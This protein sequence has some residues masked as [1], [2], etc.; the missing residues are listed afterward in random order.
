MALPVIAGVLGGI[1]A[2]AISVAALGPG[3]GD[4]ITKVMNRIF[5]ARVVPETTLTRLFWKGIITEDEFYEL[6]KFV[7]YGES[8][9]Y[10]IQASY[11]DSIS[12]G[13][14]VRLYFRYISKVDNPYG[15]NE[16]WVSKR[17]KQA[18]V[19]PSAHKEILEANRPV[20]TL[21]D[22]IRFAIR[23]V[24]EEDQAQQAGLY[25]NIPERYLTESKERGLSE[26]DA[27]LYWAAHWTL[28]SLTQVYEMFHRLYPGS[29]YNTTFTEKDMDIFFN[30]ADIAPGYREKLKEISYQPLTRVDIR[31]I[32]AMGLWGSGTTA[33][34][35]LIREYRQIGYDPFNAGVLADFTIQ[36]YGEGRK[37]FTATQI[38]KFYINEMWGSESRERALKEFRALGY[39]ASQAETILDYIDREEISTDE[40]TKVESIREQWING[41]IESEAELHTQLKQIPLTQEQTTKYIKEFETEKAKRQTRLTRSEVDRLYRSRTIS[42]SEYREYLAVLGYVE[43]DIDRLIVSLGVSR[44]YSDTL[45]GKEDVLS[46]YDNNQINDVQFISYMRE[47]GYRDEF[48]VQYAT[49]L[50]KEFPTNLEKKLTLPQ[51]GYYDELQT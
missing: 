7:G 12:V 30:L 45:P 21:E 22:V 38:R 11:G 8:A 42:E 43:K 50:G 40:K 18:G 44:T 14:V 25:E 6:M 29:G 2:S 5:Q 24:F 15:I 51:D 10:Q 39:D 16:E 13:E 36:S 34:N 37:K 32:Y 35:R 9:S 47:I 23:D 1:L 20:P 49:Q 26:S 46:W 33:R 48:I 41:L 19:D 31:R 17:L 28:P 27:K 3:P 4:V